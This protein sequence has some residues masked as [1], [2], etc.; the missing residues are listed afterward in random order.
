MT[1]D[2]R[3]SL[4][5]IGIK[6]HWHGFDGPM[7]SGIFRSQILQKRNRVHVDLYLAISPEISPNGKSETSVATQ[8]GHL[9]VE[10]T[11]IVY[12]NFTI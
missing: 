1:V 3:F 10:F 4:V 7:A 9:P 12:N 6:Q 5:R 2:A 11:F 8:A